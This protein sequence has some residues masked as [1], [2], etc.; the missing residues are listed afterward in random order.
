MN[1]EVDIMQRVLNNMEKLNIPP[2]IEREIGLR[3]DWKNNI[4]AEKTSAI[5]STAN[6]F[7]KALRKLSKN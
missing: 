5:I 3:E 1:K 6:R 7:K 4:S 2:H